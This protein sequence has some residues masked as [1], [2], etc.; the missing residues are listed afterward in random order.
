MT[1]EDTQMEHP[2]APETALPDTAEEERVQ[3]AARQRALAAQQSVGSLYGE[4]AETEPAGEA[5]LRAFRAA[6]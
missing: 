3:A 2:E 1:P 5:F 6:L 4:S